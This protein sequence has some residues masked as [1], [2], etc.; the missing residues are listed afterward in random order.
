MT[1]SATNVTLGYGE[2]DIVSG[3][4]LT[5]EPGGV[6][7]LVGPNG[8]GKSTMLRGLAGQLRARSGV[9]HVDGVNTTAMSPKDLARTVSMLPQAPVTPQGLAVKELV[10]RGRYP[11]Q[12][13]F[14][15]WRTEDEAAVVA[16]L[17]AV[18]LSELAVAPL[19]SLSGGQRQR[20][21]VAMVLAQDS[22]HV[23]L[24][25]PTTY[26]DLAHAVEVMDVIR[27]AAQDSG[28]A[29]V[30]VLHDLTLAARFADQIV[31][32]EAG[33]LVAAGTPTEVMTEEVL[34]TSFGL[35][36][37]VVDVEDA[38]AIIPRQRAEKSLSRAGRP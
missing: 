29:V 35:D 5:I 9:V 27:R 3:L 25:E 2:R 12:G 33:R 14:S 36:A 28:K 1:L 7:A 31:V 22:A 26:L 37:V 21:W 34:W 17:E 11:H 24:D 6:T 19:E 38:P 16:A 15:P 30:A 18:G 32:V 20:A 23:L 4:N 8:C 13:L 10:A